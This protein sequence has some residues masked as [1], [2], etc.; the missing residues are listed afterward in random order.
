MAR[1]AGLLARS[2]FLARGRR[3]YL[4]NEA[5]YL[6]P[7]SRPGKFLAGAYLILRDYAEG[8]FPPTFEDQ[9]LAYQAEV[10]YMDSIPGVTPATMREG[11]LR[12]PFWNSRDFRKYSRGFTRL[13]ETVER[14]GLNPGSRLL[15][16]GCGGGW[17]AEF[18]ALAGYSVV[19]TSIAPEE[20]EL[21]R[22]RI[23]SLEAK[24]LKCD[25]NFEATPMESVR[26]AVQGTFDGVF[27]FEALHH[28]FDWRKALRS[29]H[30]C[31]RPGG[32]L[33]LANEPNVAH[34]F[35]AYR[36]AR[37]SNTH[38]VGFR[39]GEL[40]SR[41]RELG[42]REIRVLSPRIDNWVSA[43]WIAARV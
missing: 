21:A 42:F 8:R 37:L 43:H 27:V 12:K 30:D 11:A 29:A 38:E 32:W 7:L 33:L 9:A 14:L 4:A 20:I 1:L 39:K 25:L 13:L 22:S 31:L 19:G 40:V 34:T 41:M 17:M 36:V 35:V 16:L 18:M 28:A 26:E 10:D 24:G 2:A 5:N 6:L 15:E 3:L 23:G